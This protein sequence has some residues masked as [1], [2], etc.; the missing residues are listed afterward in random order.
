MLR[1]AALAAVIAALAAAATPAHAEP[2]A[3]ARRAPVRADHDRRPP[4]RAGVGRPRRSRPGSRSASRRTARTPTQQTRFAILYDD[5][6]I[7]VGVWADDSD[8]SAIRRAAHAPRS[9]TRP[10]DAVVV[11]FDSYHDRRTAYVFQLNAAGVQRDLL[12]FDDTNQDDTWDAVWTGN[13]AITD[14][15]LDRRVP[16]PARPAPLRGR[17]YPRVGP[18]GRAHRR[19]HVGSRARGRR[20]RARRRRSCRRFGVVD[21]IDQPQASAPARAAAVRH[22]AASTSRRSTPAIR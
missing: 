10:A 2:R 14:T 7:Y 18:P 12:L 4:R 9:S 16:H 22:A 15:R 1:Y 5:D 20:G 6:A 8:P 3:R 13:S 19:A 11:G 17:R 21:G